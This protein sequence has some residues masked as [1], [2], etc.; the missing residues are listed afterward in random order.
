M[1]PSAGNDSAESQ[2]LQRLS[3]VVIALQTEAETQGP[4][5]TPPDGK[6]VRCDPTNDQPLEVLSVDRLAQSLLWCDLQHH[7]SSSFLLRST[8][9]SGD[10]LMSSPKSCRPRCTSSNVSNFT[11]TLVSRLTFN[12]CD[13]LLVKEVTVPAAHQQLDIPTL[14]LRSMRLSP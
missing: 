4:N 6:N 12:S 5:S 7:S 11:L 10:D 8:S 9:L 14:H 3:A 2:D 1:G 13:G